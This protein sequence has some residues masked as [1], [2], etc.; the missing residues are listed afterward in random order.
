MIPEF[1]IEQS[2]VT[3]NETMQQFLLK[4]RIFSVFASLILN[5]SVGLNDFFR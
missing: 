4:F 5:D 3:N 2:R 1:F